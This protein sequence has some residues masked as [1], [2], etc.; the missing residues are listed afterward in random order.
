MLLLL[1][2]NKMVQGMNYNLWTT[3]TTRTG[4]KARLAPARGAVLAS[5]KDPIERNREHTLWW[6]S[7][8]FRSCLARGGG[9]AFIHFYQMIHFKEG[10]KYFFKNKI[11]IFTNNNNNNC[12]KVQAKVFY[13]FLCKMNGHFRKEEI[14]RDGRRN[15]SLR[16]IRNYFLN[17]Y[18]GTIEQRIL[19][20]HFF[21][22]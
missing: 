9:G 14:G 17:T 18:V 7:T 12:L 8:L 15:P 22:S 6:T 1:L 13:G 16:D 4:N 19:L 20:A 3:T 5:Q 21:L 10:C 11:K 2:L